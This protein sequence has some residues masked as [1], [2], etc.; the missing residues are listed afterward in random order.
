MKLKNKL[1]SII[2][3]G[4]ALLVATPIVAITSCSSDQPPSV[5]STFQASEL[6][7][8]GAADINSYDIN[9]NWVFTKKSQIFSKEIADLI[10][11]ENDI[12]NVEANISDKDNTKLNVS[13]SLAN[14]QL[15]FVIEGFVP[16]S[17]ETLNALVK[18][19]LA[20]QIT[21]KKF[22][23]DASSYVFAGN[24]EGTN[25]KE[26][27]KE[28]INAISSY[29]NKK[30]NFYLISNGSNRLYSRIPTKND[31]T[32]YATVTEN[33]QDDF[34]KQLQDLLIKNK[35]IKP[36]ATIESLQLYY[37]IEPKKG[38]SLDFQNGAV[39]TYTID[40]Y[41]LWWAANNSD[42]YLV[43]GIRGSIGTLFRGFSFDVLV[44]NEAAPK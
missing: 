30:N 12:K 20:S 11:S 25:D 3:G 35:Y 9:K 42:D 15:G 19:K 16:L 28:Q 7:L 21:P 40:P 29:L 26:K 32:K 22:P 1:L 2:A 6:G 23:N 5:N 24:L 33:I 8:E 17:S 41:T 10:I 37:S 44:K 27:R 34:I 4:G 31:L 14:K 13:V 38:T 36:T 43:E 39:S 18:K